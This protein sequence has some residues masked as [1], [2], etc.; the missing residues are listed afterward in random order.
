MRVAL[1]SG[2]EDSAIDWVLQ[3]LKTGLALV[4]PDWVVDAFRYLETSAEEMNLSSYDLVHFGYFGFSH[5]DLTILGAPTT[6][7]VWHIAADRRK[8]SHAALTFT[9]F[10]QLIVE[11]VAT[12]QTLG[13]LGFTNVSPIPMPFDETRWPTLPA[14]NGPF[15]VGCFGDNVPSKRFDIIQKACSEAGVRA[16]M[17]VIP[18]LRRV[19][20]LK[21]VEDV[22]SQVHVLAHASFL[23][24]SSRTALEALAC[25]IPILSTINDG[26]RRVAN[27][28]NITFYDGSVSDLA[29][30]IREV[31]EKYEWHRE[32][33]VFT[34]FPS[35]EMIATKYAQTFEKVVADSQ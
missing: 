25:G 14:L 19:C 12:L 17:L 10:H 33:A 28:G 16:Y 8:Q 20:N 7:T 31:Q 26:L 4:R 24:T 27:G 2:R 6:A 23:D 22:Y 29:S 34:Q 32:S 9:G 11:D 13:Q 1:L 35:L 30:K 21:P 18:Q 5:P 3:D 15:T